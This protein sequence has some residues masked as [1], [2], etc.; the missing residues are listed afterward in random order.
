M[1]YCLN[2]RC[3]AP[4]NDDHAANCAACGRPLI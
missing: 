4:E 2:S 1:S 3:T